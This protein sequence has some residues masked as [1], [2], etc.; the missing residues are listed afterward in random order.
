MKNLMTPEQLIEFEEDIAQCFQNKMIRAPIHLHW[1][2]EK[3]LIEIFED[4]NEEDHI[5]CTWR[6]HY[7]HLLKGTPPEELKQAILDGRSISLCFAKYRTFSSAIVGGNL[8]IALGK[9]MEIKRR[10][11]NEHCWVFLGEMASTLGQFREV[12]QY[13]MNWDLPITFVIEDNTL[14]VKTNTRKVWNSNIL[15]FEPFDYS[16][17]A[18]YCEDGKVEKNL[19]QN[20]W[21]YKYNLHAKWQHAG[22]NIRIVF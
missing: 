18:K 7:H 8:S 22:T 12:Q 19:H 6:S 10:G 11:L 9:A 1:G 21:Y 2:N 14:S 17:K 4:V 13:A 20:V 15:P 3:Q 16:G 5:F